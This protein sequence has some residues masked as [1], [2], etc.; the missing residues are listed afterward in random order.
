MPEF[1]T[2]P[3]ALSAEQ[4]TKYLKASGALGDGRVVSVQ[5][6][7]IGTGKM[8][9]NARFTL[10]YE[11]DQETE[12]GSA[13]DTLIAKF[14]AADEQAR[15]M[16]GAHGAY[17]NEVMFY[18][19]L[20]ASTSMRTPKIYGS[21]L[22]D[23]RSS[24]LLLM[25]DMAPAEPGNNLL[26]ES[27]EHASLALGQVAKLAAAFYGDASLED[28]DYVVS[29]ARDD[30]G[31]FAQSLMEQCWSGFVDRFGHGLTPQCIAFGEHYVGN[32]CHFVTRYQGP[33]TL[34]HGDFRSENILFTPDQAATVD[35]QTVSES[36]ALADAAYFLGGSVSA[37][38]RRLWEHDLII[39]YH[40]SLGE[41]GVEIPFQECWEQYREYSMHGLMIIVLGAS[42]SSAD[43]RSDRMF[44]TLIQRHLQHCV[45]VN[46]AEFL[47]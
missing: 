39:E 40:R 19:E 22:S 38:D 37:E 14:P 45:D 7:I 21:E 9:D 27:R 11:G 46:A 2:T 16:A 36:S 30:G 17:Y 31:A 13:P 3:D 15:A 20:A 12:H 33:K 23:D 47:P 28:R 44:L 42:F 18:R 43:E 41:E 35:W 32:V 26:G 8:G 5:Q 4:L 24:F 25:E 1:S 29:A 34:I 6:K 10:R